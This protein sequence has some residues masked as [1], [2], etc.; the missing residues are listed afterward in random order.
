MER[1]GCTDIST[2]PREK[3]MAQFNWGIFTLQGLNCSM[4]TVCFRCKF[5]LLCQDSTTGLT[6]QSTVSPSTKYCRDWNNSDNTCPPGGTAGHALAVQQKDQ[7]L[8]YK[9]GKVRVLSLFYGINLQSSIVYFTFC[10]KI[11]SNPGN[12]L[13]IVSLMSS[14]QLQIIAPC[15]RTHPPPLRHLFVWSVTHHP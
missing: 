6:K 8:N 15:W 11:W 9:D 10:E 5:L 13:L 3:K 14:V 1:R 2:A 7:S 4:F 12:K